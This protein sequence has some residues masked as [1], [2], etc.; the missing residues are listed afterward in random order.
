MSTLNELIKERN[1]LQDQVKSLKGLIGNFL[2]ELDEGQSASDE[3]YTVGEYANL[4]RE[5]LESGEERDCC[6]ECGE[7]FTEKDIDGG[8]C[9]SCGRMIT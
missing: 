8:R 6:E 7:E 3:R 9:L 5:A 2:D 4:F 1:G